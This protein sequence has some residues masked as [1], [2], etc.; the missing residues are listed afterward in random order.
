M[1]R[2]TKEALH[3]RKEQDKS[4]KRD[5]LGVLQGV[6]KLGRRK[7][8]LGKLGLGKFGFG[9]IGRWGGKLGRSTTSKSA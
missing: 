8:G 3:I 4:T 1:D 5:E 7:V 6:G 9:K 2:W